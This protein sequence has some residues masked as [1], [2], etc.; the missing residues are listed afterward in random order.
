[1]VPMRSATTYRKSTPSAG[2]ISTRTSNCPSSTP[3]LNDNSDIR[4]CDPANCNVFRK[5]NEKPNPCTK[6]NAKVIAQRRL[7]L[8]PT[9]FSSAM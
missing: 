6:P 2:T 9:M 5:A 1:M 4:R 7:R 8:A 3:M